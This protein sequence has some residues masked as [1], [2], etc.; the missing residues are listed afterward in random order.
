MI[1][2][3]PLNAIQNDPVMYIAVITLTMFV[4][5]V[6]SILLDRMSDPTAAWTQLIGLWFVFWAVGVRL[7]LAG[8]R[9]VLNPE[10]TARGIFKLEGDGALVI[11][12]E[13]GF[14]N[15]AI[16][17]V[18]MLSLFFPAF[19][20]PAATYATIFYAAAGLLHVRETAR[21]RNETIAMVSD[22]GMALLLGSFALISL[23]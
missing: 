4:L 15:L 18:G 23:I 17:I 6:A 7:G 9:Q 21:G 22:L 8:G 20:L 16:G 2:A 13:L 14:A 10:F 3:T 11:V 19:A 5:P 1:R 12:R